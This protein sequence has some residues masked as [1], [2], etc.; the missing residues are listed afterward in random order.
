MGGH[1]KYWSTLDGQIKNLLCHI[2]ANSG[3]T[4][5]VYGS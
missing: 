1:N 5:G 3:K 4:G 2:M